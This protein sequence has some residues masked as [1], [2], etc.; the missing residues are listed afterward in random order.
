[1]HYRA[2]SRGKLLT[3][4]C[5]FFAGG[6]LLWQISRLIGEGEIRPILLVGIAGIALLIAGQILNDWRRGIYLFITWLLF[7]DLLRKYMGNNMA[8]Y[9]GKDILIAITYVSLLK[10]PRV[11]ND[12]PFR[13]PFRHALSLFMLLGI[14]QVL[15]PNSPSIFYG[16]LGLKLYFYYVPLMFVGYKLIVTE[17]DLHKFLVFNTGLAGLIALV[18]IIQTIVGLD[19]LNPRSGEDLDPLGHLTRYTPSGV[20]VTRPPS[21]FVSDGR[22]GS[23]LLLAFIVGMGSV[24]YL[25]LRGK[26]GSKIV[27]PA[28]ALVTVAAVMTGSRGAF[29]CVTGSLVLL[30]AGFLWGA[31]PGKLGRT[32]L[33]KAIRHSL[34]V[35][36]LAGGIMIAIFPK[37]IGARWTFYR[38][39][40]LPDSPDSELFFR[41]WTY[42]IA[43]FLG[44]WTDRDWAL[45]RGIGTSCLGL[46]YVTR[47]LGVPAPRVGV[48]NGYGALILEFG[49]LGLVLWIIW[50]L[51]LVI[52]AGRLVLKLKGT[53]AFP[54]G[55]SIAWFACFLLFPCTWG[56]LVLYQNFILNAYLWLLV[57]VLFRL[58]T[59][60]LEQ[61]Q[62]EGAKFVPVISRTAPYRSRLTVS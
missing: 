58:P 24:A 8:I 2:I 44:A 41:A 9:F 59:L 3:A 51:S 4:L 34:V 13:P 18:G 57:G 55:L 38:E 39:T 43:N 33:L 14:A 50:T 61:M 60:S 36:I 6:A 11:A 23:Y 35:I 53:W 31:P 12:G 21:I 28:V 26:H 1:M 45:G 20:A 7:E 62:S 22:F 42:P 10:A 47:I 16:L 29:S 27:F 40:V 37:Q 46:Q 52:A 17:A 32:R 48:E 54:V 49:I 15:N 25:L 30:C 19:F 56:S 5:G